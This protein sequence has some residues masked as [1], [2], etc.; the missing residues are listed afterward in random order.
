MNVTTEELQELDELTRTILASRAT[1]EHLKSLEGQGRAWDEDLWAEMGQTGLLGV[2]L[3]E[4]VGGLGFGLLAMSTVI[5][6][7]AHYV[8]PIPLW[9]AL[10]SH[11]ILSLSDDDFG[12]LLTDAV[13]GTVRVAPA[14]EEPGIADVMLPATT[15]VEGENGWTLT[16]VKTMVPHAASATHF[17]VSAITDERVELFLVEREAAEPGLSLMVSTNHDQVGRIDFEAVQAR[18]V[19]GGGIFERLIDEMLIALAALQLGTGE[20]ALE[21]TAEYVSEREQFGRPIGTFQAV[22]HQLADA[23]IGLDAVDLTQMQAISHLE[24]D[25][26]R[27]A[28]AVR[29]ASW[30]ARTAGTKALYT[31]HHVHGGIGVDVDYPL[32][33][34]FLWARQ[35]Q[36]TLGNAETMLDAVGDDLV[37]EGAKL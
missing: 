11:R 10:V 4:E 5:R 16:G 29:V 20:G 33:R 18:P 36:N 13:E 9:T 25:D 37:S 3:P 26:P 35:A 27:A 8:A 17:L 7:Q 21:L 22:Q 34:Y 15:A 19:P 14:L 28:R 23:V 2:T 1:P 31:C 30:W 32:H 24:N 12:E 6:A